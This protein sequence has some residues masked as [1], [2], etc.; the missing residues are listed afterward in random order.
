MAG[1]WRTLIAW[2]KEEIDVWWDLV[3]SALHLKASLSGEGRRNTANLQV[4]AKELNFSLYNFVNGEI[5]SVFPLLWF[6]NFLC[7]P[8]LGHFPFV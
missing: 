6:Y 3:L 7:V 2:Q 5:L 4:N 1:I 8:L